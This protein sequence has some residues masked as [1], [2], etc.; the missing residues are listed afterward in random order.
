MVIL[1]YEE[2]G[3][4]DLAVSLIGPAYWQWD[5]VHSDVPRQQTIK[6]VVYKDI[7]LEEVERAYPSSQ[8][9]EQDFRYVEHHVVAAWFDKKIAQ[10]NDDISE[11]KGDLN[12]SFYF[13]RSLYKT[14]LKIERGFHGF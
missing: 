10:F 1:D 11:G 13:L 8:V 9:K 5:R 14:A 12:I 2:F 6:V 3:P 7:G 4:S